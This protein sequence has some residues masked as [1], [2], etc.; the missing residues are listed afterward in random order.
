MC[1]GTEESQIV[2]SMGVMEFVLTEKKTFLEYVA[3]EPEPMRRSSSLPVLHGSLVDLDDEHDEQSETL[4]LQLPKHRMQVAEQCITC[5]E[6]DFGSPGAASRPG[7][8][9]GAWQLA[10]T[11]G[12]SDVSLPTCF[13]GET[14][15]GVSAWSLEMDGT[16][17][18]DLSQPLAEAS[19]EI[20]DSPSTTTG[21]SRDAHDALQPSMSVGAALHATQQ[22][23]PCA[24]YWRPGSCTR[25]AECLH[26]HLCEDGELAKRRF[27]NR[28]L[29][30]QRRKESKQAASEAHRSQ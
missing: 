16:T 5:T 30:K 14:V 10:S 27:E 19:G 23:R 8:C 25:G 18:V 12:G 20:S 2:K 6:S 29:A 17:D 4:V 9:T 15:P 7:T 1:R 11:H 3:Y 26:C 22:C 28:R 21:G 13:F 24:W